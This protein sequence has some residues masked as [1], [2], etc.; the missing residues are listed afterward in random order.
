MIALGVSPGAHVDGFAFE[1]LRCIAAGAL[2]RVQEGEPRQ[3]A[4]QSEA[5]IAASDLTDRSHRGMRD[6]FAAQGVADRIESW[7]GDAG[8]LDHVEVGSYPLIVTNPPY[9]IRV[10][11]PGAVR[12]LYGRFAI[13]AMDKGVTRL[14]VTTPRSAWM[15][16]SLRQAGFQVGEV[17]RI[18]YGAL[19]S[20]VI[21]AHA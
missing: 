9:A 2:T 16:E 13:A 8:E 17:R 6:N 20:T 7:K 21:V 12:A 5:K 10:G 19:P 4:S 11:R 18:L 14:V 3:G 1:R 15:I